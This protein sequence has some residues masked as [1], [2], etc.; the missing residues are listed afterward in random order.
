MS[1]TFSEII[2]SAVWALL[3]KYIIRIL[4]FVSF[5]VLA[6]FLDP[7][8]YAVMGI[9][10]VALTLLQTIVNYGVL[11]TVIQ[12]TDLND[13]MKHSAFWMCIISSVVMSLLVILLLP[14]VLKYF[15]QEPYYAVYVVMTALLPISSIDVIPR[16]LLRRELAYDKMLYCVTIP[17]AG[18]YLG[19][20]LFAWQGYGIWS[21]V[22][23]QV[24]NFS[25]R[26]VLFYRASGWVLKFHLSIKEIKEMRSFGRNILGSTLLPLTF[27]F[28]ERTMIGIFLGAN[29]LGYY[30]FSSQL[31]GNLGQLYNAGLFELVLPVFSRIKNDMDKIREYSANAY[32]IAFTVAS[33]ILC[34]LILLSDNLIPLFFGEQWRACVVFIQLMSITRWAAVCFLFARAITESYGKP[35]ITFQITIINTLIYVGM[36]L[37]IA[38][39]G[40]EK[41]LLACAVWS[42]IFNPISILL[43]KH[44]IRL[45]WSS[46]L[47]AV[48][49]ST[50]ST[51]IMA[52]AVILVE[53]SVHL[54]S[55]WAGLLT[56]ITVG[57][58]VYLLAISLLEYKELKVAWQYVKGRLNQSKL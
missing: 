37:V 29:V 45:E 54:Q 6:R 9:A 23:Q 5:I 39:Y 3:Q 49:P 50:I 7:E 13:G 21:L 33:P 15:D 34:G 55:A 36:L 43:L 24:I 22:A 58:L 30:V 56:G 4:T 12:R 20:V 41:Y 48:A 40:L 42:C 19:A 14:I 47:R 2:K 25:L 31:L 32:R 26:A 46:V 44:Y 16:A 52:V 17:M 10:F 28:I 27:D 38:P 35:K 18:G 53:R 11:E 51:V 1:F 57:I 8:A